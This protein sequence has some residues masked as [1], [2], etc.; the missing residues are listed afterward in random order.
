MSVQTYKR[1]SSY[2]DTLGDIE[3]ANRVDDIDYLEKAF[4]SFDKDQ[5]GFIDPQELTAA[6]TMLGIKQYEGID[7]ADGDGRLSLKDL[8]TDGD[9]KVSFEEFKVL[10]AVLPKREHAIYKGALAQKPVVMPR[11]TSRATPVMRQRAG[12]QAKT[13][14]ALQ[15][16][17]ARLCSSLGIHE[18]KRL[19]QDNFVRKKFDVLDKSKDGRVELKELKDLLRSENPDLSAKDAWMLM[20]IADTNNDKTITFDE[21]KRLMQKIGEAGGASD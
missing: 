5:S 18:V 15:D 3:S 2:G 12:A 20:N 17:L 16:A 21:F 19:R 7:D 4:K 6:L 1:Y 10:A 13:D 14:Q 9:Q 11:D 8:D